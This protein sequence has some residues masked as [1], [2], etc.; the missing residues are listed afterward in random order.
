MFGPTAT[1]I[2]RCAGTAYLVTKMFV[3]AVLHLPLFD[4]TDCV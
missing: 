2:F 3:S 4:I 1:S